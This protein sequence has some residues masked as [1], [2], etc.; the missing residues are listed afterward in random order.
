MMER[1]YEKRGVSMENKIFGIFSALTSGIIWL[2][3]GAD[4]ALKVLVILMALDFATGFCRAWATNTIS[5]QRMR[6]GFTTKAMIF[7]VIIVANM[8]DILVSQP[9]VRTFVCVFYA[10]VEG[11]SI[12]ENASALGLPI[13]EKLKSALMQLRENGRKPPRE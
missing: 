11:L 7:I 2:L 5:S 4:T 1:N 8:V 12:I 6:E 13:P 9:V 3:G 10:G